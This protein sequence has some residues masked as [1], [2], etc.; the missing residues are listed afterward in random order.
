MLSGQGQAEMIR[1][2]C[3]ALI[4][5]SVEISIGNSIFITGSAPTGQ[6]SWRPWFITTIFQFRDDAD[7]GYLAIQ[8]RS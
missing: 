7:A 8:H 3:V 1:K 4:R 5:R 6:S 2:E